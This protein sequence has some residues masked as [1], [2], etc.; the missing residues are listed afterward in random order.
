L[1]PAFYFAA[2]VYIASQRLFWFDE[3]LT[4]MI[5]RLPGWTT[6]WKALPATGTYAN[7]YDSAAKSCY[8]EINASG[9]NPDHSFARASTIFDAFEGLK[10][11]DLLFQNSSAD[12]PQ[13]VAARPRT[14][15]SR[16]S[17]NV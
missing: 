4:V 17:G 12:G 7:H 8:V 15:C 6:I 1:L 16:L 14:N 5:S 2:S 9:F 10:H 13:V 3:I 11:G